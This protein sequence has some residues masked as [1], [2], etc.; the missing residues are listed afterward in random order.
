MHI[1]IPDEGRSNYML[2]SCNHMNIGKI[3]TE[4]TFFKPFVAVMGL[5]QLM[6]RLNGVFLT[7]VAISVQM[8]SRGNK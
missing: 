2:H 3:W 1:Y 5:Y 8:P 7:T 6:P 4:S